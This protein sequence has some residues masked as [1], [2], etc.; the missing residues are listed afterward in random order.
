MQE[1]P[2]HY[3]KVH[4]STEICYTDIESRNSFSGR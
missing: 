3:K 4:E 2:K 1:V